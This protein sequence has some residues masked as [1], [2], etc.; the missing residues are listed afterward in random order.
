MDF[1]SKDTKWLNGFKNVHINAGSVPGE[2]L[3]TVIEGNGN[4]Y[5]NLNIN[6]VNPVL[7]VNDETTMSS[8]TTEIIEDVLTETNY[9][10]TFANTTTSKTIDLV[11]L[12]DIDWTAVGN[13]ITWTLESNGEG[14]KAED[15]IELTQES[16]NVIIKARGVDG[17]VNLKCKIIISGS[18]IKEIIQPINVTILE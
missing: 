11:G 5:K 4:A 1:K 15:I 13:S 7:I 9:K 17:N 16:D 8:E 2:A 18:V 14:T 6:I 10:I 3:L 12:E